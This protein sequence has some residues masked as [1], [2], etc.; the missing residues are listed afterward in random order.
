MIDTKTLAIIDERL[1]EIFPAKSN[2][3]FGG[4]NVLLCGDFFQLP[5]VGGHCLFLRPRT[6]ETTGKN[7]HNEGSL[8][9]HHLYLG[10]N[11]T[12]RLTEVMR[13]R[14]EDER[15]IRFRQA[16]GELRT[17]ELSKESW[18]LFCTRVANQLPP[19]EIDAFE[20]ALRL[21]FTNE[22]VRD[23]NSGKMVAI[24]RPVKRLLARHVGPKAAGATEDEADNLAPEL[25]LCLDA[26]V[27]LT[28]NLWTEIGLV[29]G[30]MGTVYDISWDSNQNPASDLPTRVLIRFDDYKGPGFP[31][32]PL[33]II[34][35][36][37]ITR[38]FEFKGYAC[39]RTQFPL[40]LAYAITV[41]KSQGLTLQRARLNLNKK[42]HCL[43]L[44]YVAMSRVKSLDG[45]LLEVPFDFE[46]FTV[47]K[48]PVFTDRE[49]DY[50]FRTSQLI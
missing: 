7:T 21:Y 22:E 16:L 19:P 23:E 9:G 48:S 4:L 5:P 39:S 13:Q 50:A 25:Y 49:L 12:I 34:P 47:S 17:S 11:R 40:R 2:L 18:E 3:P 1:R 28:T 20:S 29:N 6:N 32:C 14:G 33:G 8:K 10:F 31:G 15:S 35:V 30:S 42:E 26:R 45:V 41:H 37:T 46:R 27:M 38:Q 24:Q 43:G 36:F 44:S